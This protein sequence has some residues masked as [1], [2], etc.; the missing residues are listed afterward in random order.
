MRTVSPTGINLFQ[1]YWRPIFSNDQVEYCVNLPNNC[2]GG[3]IP[4]NP[5]CYTGHNGA[6]CESCDIYMIQNEERWAPSDP[7]K[8]G[9]CKESEKYNLIIIIAIS[10]LTMVSTIMSVKGTFEALQ[11]Q[12]VEDVIKMFGRRLKSD[13]SN[14]ATMV[15][16]LT[17]YFQ[18][19]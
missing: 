13:S 5:S 2:N 4:G 17:N 11:L 19:V 8:C 18:I 10:V 14:L 3:W 15:Q 6:L 16:T 9:L 7:Y 1:G 12:I